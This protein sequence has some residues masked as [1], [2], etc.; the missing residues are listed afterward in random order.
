MRVL[1]AV[2]ALALLAGCAQL[3]NVTVSDLRSAEHKRQEGDFPLSITQ[4]QQAMYEYGA[5][6]RDIG[7]LRVDPS[8]E[9]SATYTQYMPGLTDSSASLLIDLRQVSPGVTHYTA[10]TYYKGWDSRAVEV[11]DIMA[12][13][14]QCNK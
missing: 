6:C 8:N 14:K 13:K 1:L 2:V 3:K 5:N 7:P 10:Y 12:R 9:S 4:I 11:L